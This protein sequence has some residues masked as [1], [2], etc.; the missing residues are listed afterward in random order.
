MY[1]RDLPV[2]ATATPMPLATSFI[3]QEY[4]HPGM[5]PAQLA[6]VLWAH[7]KQSMLIAAGVILVV[8]LAC[9]LWPRTYEATATLMVNFEVN[10]PLGGREF[11]T[12][13]L[14]SYMATQVELA[15]GSEVLL[16]VV[17]RHKLTRNKEYAAGYSGEAGGLRDWVATGVRKN[18]L[19]EQ[20]RFGSQLIYVTYSASSPVE[21]AQV[22]NSVAE[23]YSE[24]QHQRLTVPADQ[25]AQRYTEQIAELKS[26]VAHAQ[27]QVTNFRQRSGL[28]DS[29]AKGDVSMLLLATLE[30]RLLD[31]QNARRVAE[32][33]ASADQSV[34]SQVLSSPMIQT[35]KTQLAVQSARM[36]ELRSTLGSRHPQVLELQSQNS[37][38]R[39]A[40]NNEL[41]AYSGNAASEIAS[42]R[43]LEQKLQT[44][45]E[46]QR[47]SVINVRQVQDSG[48]KY[49]LELESAQSVYKR[50]LEGYDQIM[51]ASTGG[52]SNI[53]FVSRATPPAK[54]S[55]P[56]TGIVLFLACVI[57][58]A[59]GI[60]IPLVY[61]LLNRRVRCRDDMERDHGVPVLIEL[62]SFGS[63][64]NLQARGAA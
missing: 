33:R 15:R 60:A 29:D 50:A 58:I 54:A 30:Q 25:R 47:A 49:Q 10:D 6:S 4:A 9:A 11:P 37:A 41:R 35:L 43:Q 2:L 21:A 44:A 23:V 26:K 56:K 45:V 64:G 32:A 22:A 36:A 8:A 3:P 13:L 18:L 48:A 61:E 12:G 42:A 24:Q 55:K 62:G 34:G 53:D 19:V 27:E 38:M 46:D 1:P 57:G 20:G 31:A 39:E 28:I 59:L 52:Y 5:S 63:S 40:L 14:G 51:F 16:P 7:P 17:D